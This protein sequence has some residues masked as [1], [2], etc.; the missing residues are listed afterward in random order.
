M[1]T[2]TFM[3][4]L[5][6]SSS[7]KGGKRVKRKEKAEQAE[8]ETK[9]KHKETTPTAPPKQT[10]KK[11]TPA[12]KESKGQAKKGGGVKEKPVSHVLSELLQML[13]FAY[14]LVSNTLYCLVVR[15]PM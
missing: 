9:R 5:D 15:K 10:P 7:E 12:A 8:K 1:V 4:I 6:S 11:Q 13:Q 14:F 3:K 2:P